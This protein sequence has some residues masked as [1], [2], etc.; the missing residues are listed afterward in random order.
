MPSPPNVLVVYLDDVGIGDVGASGFPTTRVATP[1]M[2]RLASEGVRFTRFYSGAA[3][4]APSRY[5]VLTGNLVQRGEYFAGAWGLGGSCRCARASGRRPPLSRRGYATA[6]V[7]KSHMGGGLRAMKGATCNCYTCSRGEFDILRGIATGRSDGRL[8]FDYNFE[9]GSGIQAP[10][11]VYFEDGKPVVVRRSADDAARWVWRR[12]TAQPFVARKGACSTCKG[13]LSLD[14]DGDGVDGENYQCTMASYA[15]EG[16]DST[17]AG[18]VYMQAALDWLGRRADSGERWYLH[19]S[20]QAVHEPHTPDTFFGAPVRGTQPTLH[21]DMVHEAD[22]QVGALMGWLEAH[23]QADNT[24]MLVT[25]DNGGLSDSQRT[26]HRA[27]GPLNSYKGSRREGGVRVPLL[28]RWPGGIPA[29]G[30]V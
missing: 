29:A 16:W 17:K 9:T 26:G 23:G 22:H 13:F 10:P 1:H 30:V 2:D 11:Y 20:S 14:P 25:S 7:G 21:L 5:N 19:F 3:L 27:S 12:A 8:G 28:A 4:C 24:L 6:F 18:E 15:Y